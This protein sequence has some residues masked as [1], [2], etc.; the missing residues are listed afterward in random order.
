MAAK[1]L[2]KDKPGR[3]VEVV[4][5]DLVQQWPLSQIPNIALMDFTSITGTIY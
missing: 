5:E 3:L 1:V 4:V 2:T